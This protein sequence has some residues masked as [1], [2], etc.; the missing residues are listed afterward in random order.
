MLHQIQ[1]IVTT[2]KDNVC[3][4]LKE[5]IDGRNPFFRLHKGFEAK[6][7]GCPLFALDFL[8]KALDFLLSAFCFKLLTCAY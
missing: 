4:P 2:E 8:H 6:K 1:E 3:E 5:K 7:A